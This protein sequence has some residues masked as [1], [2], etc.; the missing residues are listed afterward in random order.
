MSDI[1]RWTIIL[2]PLLLLPALPLR[3]AA[4]AP[5][6]SPAPPAPSPAPPASAPALPA[7]SSGRPA[8]GGSGELRLTAKQAVTR[9]LKHNLRLEVERLSPE[10][11]DAA[12]RTAEADFE[13]ELFVQLDAS[14]S[15]GQVSRQRAGLAPT[16]STTV[17]AEIGARKSF[18]TGTSVELGHNSMAMFGGG[19]LDPSYQTGVELTVKQSLLQ[20][21]S[22]SANEVAIDTA[23]LSRREAEREL[24]RKAEQA[25]ASALEAYFDLQAALAKD[26][27]QALAIETSQRTLRDTRVLIAGG[28]L[29]GSE[30]ISTRYTLQTHRRA[31][32]QAEQAVADARDKLA[33]LIGLVGP[34]SLATPAIVTVPS[35]PSLPGQQDLGRLFKGALARR[36]DFLAA[37]SRIEAQRLKVQASRHVLLPKLD[38]VGSVFFTG[39]SGDATSS[40]SGAGGSSSLD[41]ESGYWSSYKMEQVGWSAGLLFELP[42]GNRK[43]RAAL[44]SAEL[45]LRRA[46]R[47][48]DLVRQTIAQEINTAWRAVQLTREQQKLTI[49]AEEVAKTK[50]KYEEALYRAG[51]TTAHLLASVQEEAIKERLSVA[52]AAADLGKALVKLHVASGDLLERMHLSL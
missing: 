35:A 48:A 30:L 26:A 9:A 52:Q 13:P 27:I 15:P 25:A 23:R 34:G 36:G 28:K 21:I 33:R 17:G 7:P 32:L 44:Q 41:V 10:L 19:V 24:A 18:S 29:A 38:L 8:G 40:A 22:R 45:S 50:V 20:G 37:V 42:L 5:A 46:R 11:S 3:A 2:A 51:K 4:Q 14:H 16:S 12:E 6:P 47:A 1:R 39:L 49:M 31:K 43:A